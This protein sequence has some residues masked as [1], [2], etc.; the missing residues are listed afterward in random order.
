MLKSS[1]VL[2]KKSQVPS[3]KAK[4]MT[5]IINP[6]KA[7]IT[8]KDS[9]RN[10]KQSN[11]DCDDDIHK[12]SDAMCSQNPILSALNCSLDDLSRSS[13][14]RSNHETQNVRTEKYFSVPLNGATQATSESQ[15]DGDGSMFHSLKEAPHDRLPT[16][17][18]N[19]LVS[20]VTRIASL[21]G[22]DVPYHNFEHASHVMLCTAGQID[23]LRCSSDEDRAAA[24]TT[25]TMVMLREL[26]SSDPITQ[27][28]ILFA[29]L[30]HDVGHTGI[31]NAGLVSQSHPLASRYDNESVAEQ[32]SLYLVLTTLT[33]NEYANLRCCMF[34]SRLQESKQNMKTFRK[35][36]VETILCTDI[37]SDKRREIGR[38]RWAKAFEGSDH[39][40]AEEATLPSVAG[41]LLYSDEPPIDIFKARASWRQR[42]GSRRS[43]LPNTTDSP[44]VPSRPERRHTLPLQGCSEIGPAVRRMTIGPQH[45]LRETNSL[46]TAPSPSVA[47][48]DKNDEDTMADLMSL[49]TESILE[50]IMQMSDVAHCTQSYNTF[51]KWNRMLYDELY[52]AHVTDRGP[53]ILGNW[54][55]GQIGFF[56]HY[57]IPLAERLDSSGIFGSKGKTFLEGAKSNRERWVAEGEGACEAMKR[58][59][60]Q[61]FRNLS[62]DSNGDLSTPA[63]E[64]EHLASETL[65]ESVVADAAAVTSCREEEMLQPGSSHSSDSSL[66]SH[67]SAA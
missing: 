40:V 44:S 21:Y 22:S 31:S 13:G 36:M 7:S 38:G 39:T 4:S 65:M 50:Q 45:A 15:C 28:S 64:R 63:Y 20:F 47:S 3:D 9:N 16:S 12:R 41:M 57:V 66:Y 5:H 61:R 37:A 55:N 11:V 52:L 1:G 32:H 59:A 10:Y 42:R 60:Q 48:H 27:M 34:G 46:G 2:Q 51:S 54:Y 25:P 35:V 29:A 33:G 23:M 14:I 6:W 49:R 56:D 8:A 17:A 19:E 53:D 67:S 30:A 26:L 58:G 62:N 43:S 24:V 18:H